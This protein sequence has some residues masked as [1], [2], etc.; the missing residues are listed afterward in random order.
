M[1]SNERLIYKQKAKGLGNVQETKEIQIESLFARLEI[2]ISEDEMDKEVLTLIKETSEAKQLYSKTFFMIN[3]STFTEVTGVAYPAE[4]AISA[5]NLRDGV[6]NVFSTSINPGK[7]PEGVFVEAEKTFKYS[8]PRYN[9][10]KS[11]YK[12]IFD[13]VMSVISKGEPPIFFCN[14]NLSYDRDLFKTNVRV[15]KKIFEEAGEHELASKIK[16]YPYYILLFHMKH[17]ALLDEPEPD[18]ETQFPSLE[19][20]YSVTLYEEYLYTLD[21]E[22]LGCN[23]HDSIDANRHCCLSKARQYCFIVISFCANQKDKLVE[24]KHFP[25]GFCV[26]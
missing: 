5:F 2:E 20:A 9:D 11:D 16:V 1:T 8:V 15:I 4:F 24:G 3:A 12:A 14:G 13:R 10:K 25:L 21:R 7:L 26:N 19:A 6:Q 23:Y 22:A 18:H 17:F